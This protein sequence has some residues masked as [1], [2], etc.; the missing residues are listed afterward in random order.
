MKADQPL[1]SLTF[2]NDGYSL[3]AGSSLGTIY[4][5]DLRHFSRSVNSVLAHMCS[6]QR[7]ALQNVIKVKLWIYFIWI[8]LAYKQ[9]IYM[10]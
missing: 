3:F 5:Y 9:L 4:Q 6:I 1:T 10:Q 7:I 2:L 8:R